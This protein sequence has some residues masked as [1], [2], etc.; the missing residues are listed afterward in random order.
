[1]N[2]KHLKLLITL[3]ALLVLANIGIQFWQPHPATITQTAKKSRAQTTLPAPKQY[4][5]T[6]FD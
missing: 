4:A 6:P 1:M 5:Q 2:S 3:I